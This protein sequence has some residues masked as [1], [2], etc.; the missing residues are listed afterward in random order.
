M[1]PAARFMESIRQ[2]IKENRDFQQNLKLL[3]D[4]SDKLAESDAMKRAK[5]ASDAAGKTLSAG[6]EALKSAASAVGGAVSAGAKVVG[7]S[8]VG[9]ATAAAARKTAEVVDKATEPIREH[10]A[11]KAAAEN[12]S[13][14]ISEH[15]S[16]YGG[17]RT[18]EERRKA[19]DRL[20]A[21]RADPTSRAARL[22]AMSVPE[23]AEAGE[24][25]VLHKDSKWK[26]SWDKFKDNSSMMQGLFSARKSYEESENPVVEF[27]RSIT[28]KMSSIYSAIFDETETAT[29]IRAFKAIDPGFVLDDFMAEL[30]EFILPE[31]I[32]AY[33]HNDI[34]TLK[35]WCSEATFSVLSAT[36]SSMVQ[37]GLISDSRILDLRQVDLSAAKVLENDV[38][39]LVL[40]FNT[41]EVALF[42]NAKTGEIA[43]GREDHIERVFYAAVFTLQADDLDN[44][45]TNGWRLIDIAKQGS[46]AT[47]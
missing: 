35:E 21:A 40:S 1:S 17:F 8:A 19:R 26:Q 14:V 27:T 10:P 31:I 39:V 2:Q 13:Q 11:V 41:Q 15:S 47:W 42:R 12:V 44:P 43:F 46:R 36:H 4:E 38:P 29:T 20:R 16:V 23:N 30:R 24:S 25:V 33:L 28:D 34:V 37:Q 7:D 45:V 9:Q 6:G 18:K 32:E 22:R 3:S 5:E